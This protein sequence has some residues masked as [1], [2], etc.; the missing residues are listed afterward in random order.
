MG[1]FISVDFISM[2]QCRTDIIE[3]MQEA[4]PSKRI[5]I[6]PHRKSFPIRNR[7]CVEIDGK[8]IEGLPCV[9]VKQIFDRFFA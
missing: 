3:P 6:E 4:V 5:D 8:G 1:R 2:I 7:L 9:S